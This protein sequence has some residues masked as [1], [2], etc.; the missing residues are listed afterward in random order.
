MYSIEREREC[1]CVSVLVMTFI[2]KLLL[3]SFYFYFK[4]NIIYNQK[5]KNIR[6]LSLSCCC[7]P[8]DG[9]GVLPVLCS[10][11]HPGPLKIRKFISRF[12]V[13]GHLRETVLGNFLEPKNYKL[14]SS[15]LTLY[16]NKLECFVPCIIVR[17][18][19]Y[20]WAMLEQ[21]DDRK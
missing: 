5:S 6:S 15:P 8:W 13:F 9:V 3:G 12:L 10:V 17:L 20:F 2:F 7:G 19:F 11:R 18:A 1:A 14:F 21:R 4:L 16:Y